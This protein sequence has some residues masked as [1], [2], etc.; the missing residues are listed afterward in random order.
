W[1]ASRGCLFRGASSSEYVHDA[2]VALVARILEHRSVDVAQGNDCRPRFGPGRG[3]VDGEL[4]LDGGRVEARKT[5]SDL[6]GFG[7]GVLEGGAG[8]E[9]G[10]F[11]DQRAALPMAAGIPMPPMDAFGKMRAPVEGDD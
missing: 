3:V 11:D 5:F 9:I 2:V 1:A 7:I 6:Q 10:G 4:V 8:P